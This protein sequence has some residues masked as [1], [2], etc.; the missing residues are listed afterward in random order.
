ML[1][2]RFHIVLGKRKEDIWSL[3]KIVRVLNILND[4][5]FEGLLQKYQFYVVRTN[6]VACDFSVIDFPLINMNDLINVSN[7]LT[8]VDA[9]KIKSQ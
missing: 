1:K 8:T 2:L 4:V 3:V 6:N 9:S 5:L 7:I